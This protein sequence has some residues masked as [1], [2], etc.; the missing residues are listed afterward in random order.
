MQNDTERKDY[1]AGH[2]SNVVEEHVEGTCNIAM[3]LFDD[4]CRIY[5][6]MGTCDQTH[7]PDSSNMQQSAGPD[8]WGTLP[9]R[10]LHQL[11]S[12]QLE[13]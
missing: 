11:T 6:E 3:Y 5:L 4:V 1:Y 8:R 12:T 2:S 10:P 7:S 9:L 13:K